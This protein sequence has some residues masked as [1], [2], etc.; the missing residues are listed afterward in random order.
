[1]SGDETM[2]DLIM[3]VTVFFT[4]FIMAASVILIYNVFNM[5]FAE[6]TRYLG[7]LASVG[8]TGKQKRQS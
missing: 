1:M 7:M 6:R 2:G 8:A 4:V 5:S 3:F